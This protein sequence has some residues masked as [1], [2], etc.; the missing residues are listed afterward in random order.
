[1]G[2]DPRAF[3]FS[4]YFLA[5]FEVSLT[6]CIFFL[7]WAIAASL[8][9]DMSFWAAAFELFGALWGLTEIVD[10]LDLADIAGAT[11]GLGGSTAL[12]DWTLYVAVY[13]LTYSYL[14]VDGNL[15]PLSFSFV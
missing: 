6:A 10:I 12:F 11:E 8:A 7:S 9:G 3:Y 5:C 4:M 13:L 1:M 2:S 14:K 15:I